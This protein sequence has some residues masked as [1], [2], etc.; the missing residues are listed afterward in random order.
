MNFL[1][2]SRQKIESNI[3]KYNPSY[4]HIVI[5]IRDRGS[6]LA[7]LAHNS[8]R[9]GVLHLEFDDIDQ[10]VPYH[11]EAILFSPSQAKK[12]LCFVNRYI[13]QIDA[14]VVNCEA[15]I[16]RSAG[17][18]AGL[19]KIYNENDAHFFKHYLPNRHVYNIILKEY[20]KNDS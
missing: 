20:H 19:S 3:A 14:I 17:V 18:A 1:V 13:H 9:L 8:A 10:I 6:K 4:N 16:S 2:L 11:P 5:S 15:G 7:R 12:I